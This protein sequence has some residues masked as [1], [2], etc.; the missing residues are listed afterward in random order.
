MIKRILPTPA[1][2]A[3]INANSPSDTNPFATIA[4]VIGINIVT[5]PTYSSLPSPATVTNKY[6]RTLVGENSSWRPAWLGG[7]YYPEG[8]YFSDG[9]TWDYV[10]EFPYQADQLE[11]DAGVNDKNFVTPL[12]LKNAAQWSSKQDVLGYTPANKAGEAFTGNISAPNLSGSNTGDE[13]TGSIQTKRPIKTVNTISLEGVG[14]VDL[15]N[16]YTTI[17]KS[18]NQD[19]TGTT[20]NDSDFVISVDAG[21]IYQIKLSLMI[22]SNNTTAD[23]RVYFQSPSVVFKGVGSLIAWNA[24]GSTPVTASLR[25]IS[26]FSSAAA[27]GQ[28]TANIDEIQSV[29]GEV[30]YRMAAAGTLYLGFGNNVNTP[31]AISRMWAGSSIS[32]KK[33][34]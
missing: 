10:G 13:T 33:I 11:V 18:A 30:T 4:D 31:G 27:V 34:N 29:F 24:A 15:T 22:S 28:P 26:N 9:S 32:Y 25:S 8:I 2:K 17:I 19:Y 21:G 3:A 23:T 20:G 12:T 5:V 14:N 1:F 7:T 16:G 6:Y